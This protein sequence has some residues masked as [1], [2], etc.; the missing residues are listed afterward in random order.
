[1]RLLIQQGADISADSSVSYIPYNIGI[2]LNHLLSRM[3]SPPLRCLT[4]STDRC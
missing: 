4:L 1:V 2:I 3:D